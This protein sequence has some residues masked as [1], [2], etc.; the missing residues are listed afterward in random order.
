MAGKV[1]Q[2]RP[3]TR[4]MPA[5]QPFLTLCLLLLTGRCSTAVV[6]QQFAG[7]EHQQIDAW[8]IMHKQ[9]GERAFYV[10]QGRCAHPGLPGSGNTQMESRRGSCGNAQLRGTQTGKRLGAGQAGI[11]HEHQAQSLDTLDPAGG[12]NQ[13]LN[14]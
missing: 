14:Q 9:P 5:Q 13:P 4:Q 10:C 11:E 12:H 3:V 6:R 8:I 2:Q 7:I 1:R